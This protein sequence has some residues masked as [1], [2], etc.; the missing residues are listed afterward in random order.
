MLTDAQIRQ[1]KPRDRDYKLSDYGHLF[2][3][4][5]PNGAKLWRLG[6]RFGGKQ[7]SLALG[8][9]PTVG[10]ADARERREESRKPPSASE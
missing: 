3:L 6:Y 4:I 5:R 9:Y 2:L 10:L 1:A 7:K 8:A